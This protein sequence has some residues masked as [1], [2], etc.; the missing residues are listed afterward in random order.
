MMSKLMSKA[1][2][3]R[4]CPQPVRAFSS[5]LHTINPKNNKSQGDRQT[6]IHG[7]YR[8]D[9]YN[10]IRHDKKWQQRIIKREDD[11]FEKWVTLVA[12][13]YDQWRKHV[14]GRHD[15][16]VESLAEKYGDYVYFINQKEFT[17]KIQVPKLAKDEV[18]EQS[19]QGIRNTYDIY[20]RYKYDADKGPNV[21]S[22]N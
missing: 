14:F 11:N 19:K 9:S 12:F 3:L 17:Q 22:I 6:K 8:F 13:H 5:S 7:H 16:Q 4:R 20:C 18:A 15:P 21:K 1:K 10:E 2:L